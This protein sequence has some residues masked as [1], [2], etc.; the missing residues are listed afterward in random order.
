MR[1]ETTVPAHDTHANARVVNLI[2]HSSAGNKVAIILPKPVSRHPDDP[3]R[4]DS[5]D[6]EAI[7]RDI[8]LPIGQHHRVREHERNVHERV[9][10]PDAPVCAVAEP[11]PILRVL[12]RAALGVEPALGLERLGLGVYVGVVQRVVEG[13]NEE[14]AGR[15]GVVLADLE[16]LDGLV[17]D[18][19]G[20]LGRDDE[21]WREY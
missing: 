12:V 13:R 4:Y 1:Q 17:G 18:L 11:D 9:L 7:L 5:L 8:V 6:F 20:E 19:G 3:T 15:N 2:L 16:R 10:L 21:R 14:R